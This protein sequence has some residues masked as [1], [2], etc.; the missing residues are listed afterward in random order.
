VTHAAVPHSLDFMAYAFLQQG[1]D[2]EA[3]AVVADAAAIREL[4]VVQLAQATGLAAI[5]VRYALERGAWAEAAALEVRPTS[6]PYAE[7][8]ARYGRALGAARLGTP[9]S[10]AQARAEIE[11]M[12]RLR[13]ADQA[14]AG[15]AYWAEQTEILV[16]SA[17]GWLARAEGDSAEALRRLRAGADLEDASEKHVAME[18]RLL[19]VREQLGELLL[20]LGRPEAA[21]AEFQASMR[22]APNRLRGTYGAARAADRAGYAAIAQDYRDRLRRLTANASG[23]RAEVAYA[24]GEPTARR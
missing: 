16:D 2:R 20:E 17:S 19:P 14:R 9:E 5:P 10:L 18:N 6:F 22:A 13:A 8:V 21:L 4:N 7:A 1:R 24:R 23:D 15:Q 11:R 3:R 12:E